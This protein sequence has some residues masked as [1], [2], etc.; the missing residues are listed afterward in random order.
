MRRM[1]SGYPMLPDVIDRARFWVG[2]LELQWALAGIKFNHT[3]LSLAHIGLAREVQPVGTRLSQLAI[4]NNKRHAYLSL[5]T[6]KARESSF[7]STSSA[8]LFYCHLPTF[9]ID[10]VLGA[11]DTQILNQLDGELRQPKYDKANQLLH[12]RSH[13]LD[14]P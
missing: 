1:E 10:D 6:G 14:H 7:L 11:C 3:S 8:R 5:A 12:L 13:L 9:F 4:A 2:T